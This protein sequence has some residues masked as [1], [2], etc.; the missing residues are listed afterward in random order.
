M[1]ITTKVKI[2]LLSEGSSGRRPIRVDTFDGTVFLHGTVSSKAE[3]KRLERLAIE[4]YGVRNVESMIAVSP[5]SAHD[6]AERADDELREVITALLDRDRALADSPIEVASV[7]DG[8]VVLTG[9]AATL[10]AHRRALEDVRSIEGVRRVV[11]QIDSPDSLG[12]D[13]V[14]RRSPSSGD[15]S[16]DDHTPNSAAADIWIT[17]KAKVRL[18]AEPGL[19]PFSV[20]V[21]TRD[22]VVTL[23]GTVE[24]AAV[25]A[26]A[27]S[28]VEQI[29]GVEAVENEIQVVERAL[30]EGQEQA[31]EAVAER[32]RQKLSDLP[33]AADRGIEVAVENGAV[34]LS[35]KVRSEE[36]RLR[37]LTR[38]SRAPGVSY[39]ID[40]LEV[41]VDRRR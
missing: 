7:T 39:V 27:G 36:D 11:S 40:G 15:D 18:M 10:S 26:R 20:R 8:V 24:S 3:R 13:E 33:S 12:D 22:G 21:D 37:A 9:E 16:Q 14:W 30:A 41:E 4:V 35:G 34:R 25:R 31:D 6:L 17:T 1:W 19:S 5:S 28:V 29:S 23:F 32:V 38:A 2:A